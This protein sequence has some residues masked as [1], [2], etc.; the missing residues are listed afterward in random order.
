MRPLLLVNGTMKICELNTNG[1]R[2]IGGVTAVMKHG[3]TSAAIKAVQKQRLQKIIISSKH[4]PRTVR[5]SGIV[6]N[7]LTTSFLAGMVRSLPIQVLTG[8]GEQGLLLG[9]C[10]LFGGYMSIQKRPVKLEFPSGRGPW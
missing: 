9:D 4:S 10:S 3:L 1:Y 6:P 2:C 5:S 7:N 8:G